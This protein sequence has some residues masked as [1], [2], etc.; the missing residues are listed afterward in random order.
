[1]NFKAWFEN[2]E[3]LRS[4]ESLYQKIEPQ[5]L[6]SK[7]IQDELKNKGMVRISTIQKELSLP[8]G[9]ANYIA[10]ELNKRHEDKNQISQNWASKLKQSIEDDYLYHIALK[11]NLGEILKSGLKP[12][13]NATATNYRNYSKGKVFLTEK[14]GIT[15][16][17]HRIENYEIDNYDD[18]EGV[19]VLRVKKV[20]LPL[21]HPD[22][23][24]TEDANVNAYFV[25]NPIAPNLIEISP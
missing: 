24:G 4:L 21:L 7:V 16:W 25:K 14:G 19:I 3:L 18:P 10:R 13:Q 20:N 15:F 9:E 6:R 17:R 23:L 11:R 2:N 1:M 5:L 22:K 8:E 12:N